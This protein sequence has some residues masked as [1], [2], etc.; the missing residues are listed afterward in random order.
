MAVAAPAK[1]P[2]GSELL[3][4]SKAADW[5]TPDQ[6][7]LL[8]LELTQG[9]VVIELSPEYAP[10]H[11]ARIKSLAGQKYWDGLAVVRVQDG[12]VAQWAD[13]NAEKPELK[14][15]FNGSDEVLP[16]ELDIE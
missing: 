16:A 11:V 6:A 8:Y 13:P 3:E 10:R 4:T 9:R 7:N 5:R 14:R 12:Y 2:I 15:K 1:K